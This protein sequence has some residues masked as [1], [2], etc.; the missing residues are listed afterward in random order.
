VEDRKAIEFT[1]TPVGALI[2]GSTGQT[3]KVKSTDGFNLYDIPMGRYSI[4]AS[5]NGTPLKLR[6]W[7]TNDSFVTS[8]QADFQPQIAQQCNNCI[9]LEYTK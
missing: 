2:D 5:F 6:R 4:S 1:L 7:N 8:L 9:K 3:L